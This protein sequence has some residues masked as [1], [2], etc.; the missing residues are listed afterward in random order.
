MRFLCSSIYHTNWFLKSNLKFHCHFLW[1][2][3]VFQFL[4]YGWILS[5]NCSASDSTKVS[6]SFALHWFMETNLISPTNGPQAKWDCKIHNKK[7]EN[8]PCLYT[9]KRQDRNIPTAKVIQFIT[10]SP[11]STLINSLFLSIFR[12]YSSQKFSHSNM[13][14]QD[15]HY[16]LHMWTDQ[17][18]WLWH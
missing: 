2:R 12:E 13:I 1:V 11:L 17:D 15:T 3:M 18:I 9:S 4:S 6:E 14:T 8:L 7:T 16:F 10:T 5:N